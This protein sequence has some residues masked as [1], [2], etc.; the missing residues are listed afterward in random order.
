M[1]DPAQQRD[2]AR[3]LEQTQTIE[4]P[5]GISGFNSFY[6]TGSFVPTWVGTTIAG[7]FTYVGASCIVEWSRIGN[8]LFYNGR[9]EISAIGVAPTGNLT[10]AGWPYPA[11]SNAGMLIAGGGAFIVWALNLAAGYTYTALQAV[12]GSS[13]L[14]VVRSGDNVAPAVVLGGELIVG[15]C[16]FEGHYRVA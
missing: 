3:R 14:G 11:V 12:N 1:S 7:T 8:R 6:E 4:R 16:W 5:G 2:I 9:I 15:N 13:V 10:L